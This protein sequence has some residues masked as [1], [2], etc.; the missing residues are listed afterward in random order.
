[1]KN[2]WLAKSNAVYGY[3]RQILIA[4]WND[5]ARSTAALAVG[6]RY[7]APSFAIGA[8][9]LR[10]Y[11]LEVDARSFARVACYRFCSFANAALLWGAA[12]GRII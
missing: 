10:R 7:A 2:D 4:K 5:E 3:A 8:S 9:P 1:M 11:S 6:T 12:A